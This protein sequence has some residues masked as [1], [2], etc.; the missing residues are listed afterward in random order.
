VAIVLTAVGWRA[1]AAQKI[2]AMSS[3]KLSATGADGPQDLKL[4]SE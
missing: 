1:L 2:R 3:A 4:L